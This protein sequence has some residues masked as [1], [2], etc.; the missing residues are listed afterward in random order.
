M[1]DT[2]PTTG[3]TIAMPGSAPG[4]AAW[5]KVMAEKQR[6]LRSMAQRGG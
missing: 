5:R 4:D 2:D 1:T 3:M 6:L